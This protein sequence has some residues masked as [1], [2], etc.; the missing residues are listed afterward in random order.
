MVLFVLTLTF[1][2]DFHVY[3]FVEM[4]AIRTHV[5]MF[6]TQIDESTHRFGLPSSPI[7]FKDVVL[8]E[9]SVCADVKHLPAQIALLLTLHD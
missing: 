4:D 3:V 6:G 7:S 8:V 9:S 5:V 1:T 2:L